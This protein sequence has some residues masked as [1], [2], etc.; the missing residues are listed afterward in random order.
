MR[1]DS[2]K[3]KPRLIGAFLIVALIAA[4]IGWMGL[5]GMSQTRKAQDDIATIFLPSV[6]GL[7]IICAG[8]IDARL[9]ERSMINPKIDRAEIKHQVQRQAESFAEIER[10]W[11]LYA[12]LPQTKD[13]TAVWKKFVPAYK[14]WE[15]CAKEITR[16]AVAGQGDAAYKMS[17]TQGRDKYNALKG[18][19]TKLIEI[20]LNNANNADKTADTAADRTYKSVIAFIV[21]GVLASIALGLFIAMSVANP[22]KKL[23][24]VAEKL[25]V[26]DVGVSVDARSKDEIGDLSRCLKDV[27]ENIQANAKAADRISAGDLTI[28]IQAK[29][30]KD[31]LAKSMKRVVESLRGL[32]SEAGMLGK[33]GI[34]GRLEIRGDA[35]KFEGGYRDIIQGV[36]DTLDTVIGH[37]DSI[38]NPAMIID[39]D[40]SIKFVNETAAKLL[41]QTK[42]QLIGAKC[43]DQFKTSDCRT[44]N[45]ACALAMQRGTTVNR[46]TEAHPNGKDMDIA[47]S[48]VPL[49]DREGNVIGA[50]E[51]ALD[52]TAI[53]KAARLSQKIAEFQD[54]EVSKLNEALARFADRDLTVRDYVEDGDYD[55][56][57]VRAKFVQ[58]TD[59]FNEC[60]EAMSQ[61][62]LQVT[63]SATKVAGSSQMLSAAVADVGKGAE[64]IT[65]TIQQVATGSQEQ[66]RTVRGSAAAMEQLGRS[67]GEVAQGAQTQAQ[68]VD[69]TV[70]LVQQISTAIDQ[71]AKSAQD[72]ATTSQQVSDVATE[73]G[74]QVAEAV[75]SMDRIKEATDRVAQM[76]KQL[77]ES[78]QQIGAIVETID[79]IAEQTN[80]LALNAAIEAARAGEHGKGFA[81][82]ADEVRKLAER[83]SKAT[84]EIAELI[85]GI[86]QMT[87]HAVNAMEAGS[88]EVA[89]GTALG[90][91]AGQALQRIQ[92]AVASVVQQA[93]EVSA[94]AQQMTSSS[95]EVIRAIENVSAITEESTAATEEMAAASSEVANQIEQVAAVSEEN[96]AASEE[97]AAT[98]QQQNASVEEMTSAAEELSMMA[99][100]LQELVSQF[101]VGN[102]G[103]AISRAD[104]SNQMPN[105]QDVS[106]QV[107][108]RKR[109]KAA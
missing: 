72:A 48:G 8:Q 97:V 10:G 81:V 67:I 69:D 60:V 23:S 71:V 2:I 73:G 99:K 54:V 53:K 19:R 84:G 7:Y 4:L 65:E 42:Q 62:I 83:S 49:K 105:L 86:R 12:P 18:L 25:A 51:V 40:F 96:A 78:S 82:V 37:I 98:A 61:A 20:N 59:A 89:D 44:E 70:G 101:K 57:E 52:H 104:E 106:A 5:S 30:D 100:N 64:Q 28:E 94:A 107:S 33:A 36:N 24:G 14:N 103:I 27:V 22:V 87:D 58:I 46:E 9:A 66:S 93:Q 88:K 26:G 55:T 13:E 34:E 56:T 31:V 38:P 63:E 79:D 91:Q 32:V 85:G 108:S 11:K 80:L 1:L 35:E 21:T 95:G 6:E 77:G 50:F 39:K 43:Y 75:G 15:R 3:I 45:C 92:S 109:R 90:N 17:I 76:V 41:G 47:Y 68:V 16:L 74:Q 29:S 102:A